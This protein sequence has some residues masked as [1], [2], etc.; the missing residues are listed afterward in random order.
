[1]TYGWDNPG[2]NT[3]MKGKMQSTVR[4]SFKSQIL[5]RKL[6]VLLMENSELYCFQF[7]NFLIKV[8]CTKISHDL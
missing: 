2:R 7:Y 6:Y 1:M 4:A 5:E 3:F 8:G